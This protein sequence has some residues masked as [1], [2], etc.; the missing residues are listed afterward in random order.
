MMEVTIVLTAK[1]L[2]YWQL[3]NGD[4]RDLTIL[5]R[6]KVGEYE[7]VSLD[8]LLALDKE[9]SKRIVPDAE[10]AIL[11]SRFDAAFEPWTTNKEQPNA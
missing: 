4:S 11:H 9:G 8:R 3:F 6:D 1:S 10:T 7:A 5:V 2:Q